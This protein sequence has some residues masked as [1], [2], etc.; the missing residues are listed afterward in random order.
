MK[1]VLTGTTN[2]GP[3]R[4]SGSEFD[5][6]KKLTGDLFKVPKAELNEKRRG[7]GADGESGRHGD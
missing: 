4:K 5:R 2:T 7:S 1:P 3:R 6:F